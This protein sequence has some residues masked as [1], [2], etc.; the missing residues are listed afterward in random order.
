MECAGVNGERSDAMLRPGGPA[1]LSYFVRLLYPLT[2]NFF[3]L[4]ATF[5]L[6]SCFDLVSP[7]NIE[8]FHMYT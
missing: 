4:I 7:A 3:D 6:L 8:K 2:L 1:Y 5:Q